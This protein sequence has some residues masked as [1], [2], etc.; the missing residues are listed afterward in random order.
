MRLVKTLPFLLSLSAA[1]GSAS[2]WALPTDRDQPIR[3]QADN[4]HL[5]DKKGV[6]TYTGDVIITQGSMMIKGNTVTITRADSGDI[7][8]VTSVGNL[9]YFEQQQSADKPDK[10][11]GWAVTI[12]YQS[13]KELVVL[14]DRAKVENEGN[15]TEGEKIVYNTKS[16]VA[17]AGRG[18]NVTTPR[19]R[20]DMV[21]QPKKKAE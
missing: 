2:A 16:Q 12:Q 1:L 13:Q 11:K 14:T 7:D 19:Q 20:I 9:A 8:V 6:A 3:I 10:M 5:D 18:S 21:I 17:T 15:T 4:A